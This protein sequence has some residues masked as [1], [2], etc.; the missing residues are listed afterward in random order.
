MSEAA[1]GRILTAEPRKPTATASDVWTVGRIIDWTTGYLKQHGSDT[2]RLDAEVLLSH[3]RNC[4]R[5]QLYARYD[6]VLTDAERATMRDLVRRRAQAEPVAYLVG[7]R[8]FF[9]LAFRVTRDVLI[10]RPDTESLVLELIERARKLPRP[11]IAEVGTGSGCIAISVAVNLPQA[12]LTTIDISPAA[13][14]V[15]RENAAAHKVSERIR[16]LEG[17]LLSPLASEEAFDF[18]VSNPPYIPTEVLAE[19]D[20][21]VRDH[22]PHLALNGGPQGMTVLTRLIQAAPAHLKPGGW[23]L[24]EIG[25]EQPDLVQSVLN[26]CGAYRNIQVIKDLEGRPRV[27]VAEHVGV[28]PASGGS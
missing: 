23:L 19:L 14:A 1:K 22:E 4:P 24:L 18:I 11:R 17:D 12:E 16:F 28:P 7:H 10:P 20:A 8:E 21:D 5:I 15:A 27:V 2:P 13:L 26:Q 3:T 25:M 6:D 9:S